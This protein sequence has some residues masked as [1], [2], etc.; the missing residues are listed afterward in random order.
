MAKAKRPTTRAARAARKGKPNTSGLVPFKKG[1]P[2]LGRPKGV[3]NKLGVLI[4]EAIVTA[5]EKSGR[6]G[7]GKDGAVGY[8]VWLSRN[9]P[10]VFGGLVGK[11]LPMQL[12]VK[13][14]TDNKYTPAEAIERLRER[15]LPVP[16]SLT[17][18]AGQVGRAVMERQEEDYEDELVDVDADEGDNAE[19][20]PDEA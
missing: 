20:E 6:D 11:V 7:K 8:F 13:D 5:L 15:G 2:G 14:K 17:S 9:E 19:D 10:A 3:K 4:K 16:P 18:L 1:Q 12:E